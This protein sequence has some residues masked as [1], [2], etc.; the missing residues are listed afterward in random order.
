MARSRR[1]APPPTPADVIAAR[2]KAVSLRQCYLRLLGRVLCLAAVC[3]LL[4][5]HV[6]LLMQARGNE[7][8]PAIKDG[9]LVI[10]FRLG[11]DYAKNDVVVYTVGGE[12]RI[13]RIIA[14]SGDVVMLDESGTLLVNG[15]VQRGAIVYPSYAKEAIE[16]PYT[17]PPGRVFL[18]GDHRTQSVDS[19]DHG[20]LSVRAVQAKVITI[21]RR[22]GI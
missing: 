8:F 7:M 20:A 9:D 13:G 19:R 15:G 14:Q 18:L 2:R 11:R 4:F 3:W 17:V 22:R 16:Y 6:F 5:S 10:A 21:V 1:G 12:R